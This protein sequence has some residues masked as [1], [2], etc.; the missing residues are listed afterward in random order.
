MCFIYEEQMMKAGRL[1]VIHE[2]YS[3]EGHHLLFLKMKVVHLG[4]LSKCLI[5]RLKIN[6]RKVCEPMNMQ[7][8]CMC[9][10][11]LLTMALS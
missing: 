1:E 7:E 9:V 8:L 10:Y 2:D 11:A 3:L 5:S 6:N 4:T